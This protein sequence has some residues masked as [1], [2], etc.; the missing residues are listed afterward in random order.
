MG[1]S[2]LAVCNLGE[3]SFTMAN[4]DSPAFTPVQ[5]PSAPQQPLPS[6]VSMVI[7]ES[8]VTAPNR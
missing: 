1:Y 6:S 7:K 5:L 3:M 8:G 2:N 4:N